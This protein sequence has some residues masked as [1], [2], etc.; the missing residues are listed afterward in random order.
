MNFIHQPLL[1]VEIHN[2][3]ANSQQVTNQT[4]VM[5]NYLHPNSLDQITLSVAAAN[6]CE[7]PIFTGIGMAK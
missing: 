6:K 2:F 1:K 4:V 3:L 5:S 7:K